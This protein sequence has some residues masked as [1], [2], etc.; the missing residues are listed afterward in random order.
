MVSNPYGDNGMQ[1]YTILEF[2]DR[3]CDYF[4]DVV[5][6]FDFCDGSPIRMLK[7]MEDL[8]E[9]VDRSTAHDRYTDFQMADW[10]EQLNSLWT[11]T[12]LRSITF[13]VSELRCP[14]GCCRYDSL[15]LFCEHIVGGTV[16]APYS[17]LLRKWVTQQ[18]RSQHAVSK[19]VGLKDEHEKALFCEVA[20]CQFE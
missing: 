20:T 1:V 3:Y 8:N 13:N 2:Y 15:D 18:S 14:L 16:E 5:I 12:D 7:I 6:R 17:E 11:M 10:E 9:V 4:R 19:I